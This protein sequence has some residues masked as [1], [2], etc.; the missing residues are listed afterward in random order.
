VGLTIGDGGRLELDKD[1]LK[2]AIEQDPQA[3][4]D[5]LIAREIDQSGGKTVL[6]GGIEVT[7]PSAR[8]TFSSLGVF[9]RIEELSKTYIDSVD[10]VLTARGRALDNQV[11]LQEDRIAFFD[12]KL[13]DKR[14]RLEREFASLETI[15]SNFQAQQAALSSLT[16]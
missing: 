9:A 3:V 8:E 15:I 7:D 10:G 11:Q 5:L 14:S 12:I 1:K 2:E 13:A 16:G 4:E 6:E